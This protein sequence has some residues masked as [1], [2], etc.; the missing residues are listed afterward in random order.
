MIGEGEDGGAVQARGLQPIALEAKEG[1]AFV[2]GTQAQTGVAALVGYDAWVLWRTAHAAAAVSLW[3]PRGSSL[4]CY[5][6]IHEAPPH[7]SHQ[8]SAALLRGML[9]A[10]DIRR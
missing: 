3:A 8:R 9:A 4:P 5:P 2:N 7:R 1:L 6:V 10:A